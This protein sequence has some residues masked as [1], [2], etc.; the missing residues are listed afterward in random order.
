MSRYKKSIIYKQAV[1]DAK[2]YTDNDFSGFITY[3]GNS[4]S[5]NIYPAQF[6]F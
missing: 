3:L 5:N 2:E 6:N 4:S 1:I